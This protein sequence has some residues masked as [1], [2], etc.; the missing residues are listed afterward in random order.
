[1]ESVTVQSESETL[2]ALWGKSMSQKESLPKEKERKKR[3]ACPAGTCVKLGGNKLQ[4][5][6]NSAPFRILLFRGWQLWT[7][8]AWPSLWLL[9]E[10]NLILDVARDGM[11][12][13]SSYNSYS[14]WS[15]PVELAVTVAPFPWP[16]FLQ[17][18]N[19][20]NSNTIKASSLVRNKKGFLL[21]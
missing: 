17:L 14:T 11:T 16:Q 20:M 21:G 5:W 1:M 4:P 15:V 8:A 10:S 6:I 3:K 9:S 18:W 19:S 12:R 2:W 7:I 13:E